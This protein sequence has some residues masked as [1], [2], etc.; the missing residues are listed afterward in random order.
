MANKNSGTVVIGSDHAGFEMKEFVKK[1]LLE[2]G[3]PF[4]DV[5]ALTNDPADDYPLFASKV[6]QCIASGKF[7]KG[8]LM[9]GSGVGASIAANRH[10]K[11]RAAL[12]TT[13]ETARMSRLHND[14][15]ILVI[16]GRVTPTE[17]AAKMMDIWLKTEFEGG[18]HQKRIDQLDQLC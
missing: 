7:D 18:R 3:I 17:V 16:G 6:A 11:V 12:C 4:H 15:N 10:K 13:P 5:G 14:S 8:I 9:C 2:K 1:Y